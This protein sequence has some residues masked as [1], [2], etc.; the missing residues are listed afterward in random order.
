MLVHSAEVRVNV[1][2]F[3]SSVMSDWENSAVR[4][5]HIG[6][7]LKELGVIKDDKPSIL[8]SFEVGQVKAWHKKDE[9]VLVEVEDLIRDRAIKRFKR[10]RERSYCELIQW[11]GSDT[12]KKLY[13]I[14][15]QRSKGDEHLIVTAVPS[16]DDAIK[17]L[18]E[19]DP[20]FQEIP[21]ED[22]LSMRVG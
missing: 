15:Q 18:L 14:Y 3:I 5:K 21:N 9:K 7:G 10:P 11:H 20:T 16:P 1:S 13:T 4:F 6:D 17:K 2:I 12:G 19:S 22:L 8:V